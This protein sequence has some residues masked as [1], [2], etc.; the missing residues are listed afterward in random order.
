VPARE[1]VFDLRRAA[2]AAIR[3]GRGNESLTLRELVTAEA[4]S[5]H[6]VIRRCRRTIV[7]LSHW[8]DSFH[9]PREEC[10]AGYH[11]RC[12]VELAIESAGQ[13]QTVHLEMRMGEFAWA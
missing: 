8:T 3:S 7:H 11:R 2:F 1:A 13:Q 5:C 4:E 9:W 12:V 6:Y 10:T